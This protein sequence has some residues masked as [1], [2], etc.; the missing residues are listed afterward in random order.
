MHGISIDADRLG[1]GD[2]AC[3]ANGQRARPA[4]AV[5]QA[6]A[7]LEVGQ[8]ERSVAFGGAAFHPF[9]RTLAVAESVILRRHLRDARAVR[10]F[11]LDFP[12]RYAL[13]SFQVG[14]LVF[15]EQG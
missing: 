10:Y 2:V 3:K 15:A 9:H 8:Q 1:R 7:G 13:A 12:P 4:S 6:H 11:H 14:R 5:E